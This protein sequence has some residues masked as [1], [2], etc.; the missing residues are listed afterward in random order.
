VADA[1]SDLLA[2]ADAVTESVAEDGFSRELRRLGL[3]ASGEP[4]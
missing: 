2:V 3:T 1:H 4:S